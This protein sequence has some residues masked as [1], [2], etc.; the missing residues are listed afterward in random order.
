ME[1]AR[2]ISSVDPL[3]AQQTPCDTLPI[4]QNLVVARL[5]DTADSPVSPRITHL[6]PSIPRSPTPSMVPPTVQDHD[7]HD[8]TS[9]VSLPH[10]PLPGTLNTRK[11]CVRHKRMADEGSNVAMQQS[12]DLLPM[13][14]REAVNRIWSAFSSSSHPSRGLILK[15]ILTMCCFSQLS[16]LSNELSNII[17]LDPFSVFPPEISLR[18]LAY[19]DAISLGRAAQVSRKW[20]RLADDDTLW[21]GICEQ[22]INKKCNKCGWGLPLMKKP[23]PSPLKRQR[24]DADIPN[25]PIKRIKT[26]SGRATCEPLAVFRE[27]TPQPVLSA[28]TSE[29][30]TRPWKNVYCERL[31][32]ER[33]WRSGRFVGRTLK[34]HTAS[35]MCLQFAEN[36]A[37]V[38]YPVLITG[39]YD[40]TVRV[41]N[42]AEAKELRCIRGHT[43]AIRALQFDDVKLIT[44]SMDSTLRIWNWRTGECVKELRG[45]SAGVVTLTF[46]ADVLVSGSVDTTV[47]VW[48]F[49]N[50]D[51]FVLRGHLDWV[52]CVLLWNDPTRAKS[53]ATPD[54]DPNHIASG[55]MLF[56]SSDDGMVRLWDL[57]TRACIRSFTGHTG[58]VQSFKVL[59][60]DRSKLMMYYAARLQSA[61]ATGISA[62]GHPYSTLPSGLPGFAPANVSIPSPP[63]SDHPGYQSPAF[64]P[65]DGFDPT[66]YRTNPTSSPVDAAYTHVKPRFVPEVQAEPIGSRP[67]PILV[68]GSLDNTIRVWDVETGRIINTL[69]GHIEGVWAVAGDKLRIVSGSHDRTIKIWD[70]E[71]GTCQTT[72]VGHRGA[73]TCVALTD[74]K[75]VSG[76]DDGDI[77]IWDFGGLD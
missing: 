43:R 37:T 58:Q 50:Q 57:S 27:S 54:S 67:V 11:L 52:N 66:A 61:R 45:H 75:I 48:N 30:R 13:S 3:E 12:L 4:P 63:S 5:L 2:D 71:T 24:S 44:G 65:P 32:V 69:F 46:D 23:P 21:K 76:S 51:S 38:K 15:G 9:V 64:T 33:N 35:V 7:M 47:R 16:L 20:R 39:S 42:M 53:P 77:K 59:M 72:L 22:H 8:E 10:P 49:R 31:S 41:W 55:K 28:S 73:V 60:V 14:E 34:G 36:L 18:I 74:D 6:D 19:L 68:T 62:N 17:R 26:E 40:H 29:P 56:S 1:S 70:R 25:Q